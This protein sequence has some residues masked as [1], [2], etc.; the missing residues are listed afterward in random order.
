MNTNFTSCVRA[1]AAA[2]RWV[3]VFP[4]R[5]LSA[6]RISV[7]LANTVQDL[8]T[9][10]S[11]LLGMAN[12]FAAEAENQ[13]WIKLTPELGDYPH[14]RGLQRIDKAAV[15]AMANHF[16]RARGVPFYVGHPDVPGMESEYP[17]KKAYGWVKEVEA[18]ADGL[19]GKV[20]WSEPGKAMLANS[21]FRFF[22]PYWNSATIGQGANG[23]PI[24]RPLELL[25]VALTNQPNLPVNPLANEEETRTNQQDFMKRE[26]I[27]AALGLANTVTDAE[28][29]TR[30]AACVAAYTSLANVQTEAANAKTALSNEQAAH[31]T[32]K[33][34]LETQLA[35]TKTELATH[36]RGRAEL[37][38]DAAIAEGRV[39]LANRAQWIT[40]MENDFTGKSTALANEKKAVKTDA[41][42][43][44]AG[45]R[46]GGD[47]T[48]LANEQQRR[49][50][51]TALM[52]EKVGRGIPYDVAWSEVQRE[53]PELFAAMVKPESET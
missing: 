40:D 15:E 19:Y 41:R 16:K 7:A 31:S 2:F 45:S 46:R 29:T 37:L 28:I 26:E 22:S 21:H 51:V 33:S 42:T 5:G 47:A 39:P 32:T 17:D 49:S 44:G 10:L 6:R 52:N 53:K 24:F 27:I 20:K 43:A 30:L 3:C 25:S 34:S 23:K 4:W 11:A 48:A 14:A 38:V 35:N 12:V 36:R 1:I 18:R 9:G 50:Q 8:R 13:E